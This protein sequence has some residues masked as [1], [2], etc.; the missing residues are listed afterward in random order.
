MSRDHTLQINLDE[1]RISSNAEVLLTEETMY[2]SRI[3]NDISDI[4]KF[5]NKRAEN[6][7]V[8]MK[9]V[10]FMKEWLMIWN[11][12]LPFYENMSVLIWPVWHS[13][14]FWNKFFG[15][16]IHFWTFLFPPFRF[17]TFTTQLSGFWGKIISPCSSGNY[18]DIIFLFYMVQSGQVK[19]SH[20]SEAGKALLAAILQ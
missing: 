16:L 2:L 4:W 3:R 1:P 10:C 15:V 17:S 6:Q 8:H 14:V 9:L 7:K 19:W 11:L 13:H 18:I 5:T 20:F 12:I